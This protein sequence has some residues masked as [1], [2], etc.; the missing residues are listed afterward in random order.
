MTD[1]YKVGDNVWAIYVDRCSGK[2][3]R[4]HNR[5]PMLGKLIGHNEE[6]TQLYWF[7]PYKV[8]RGKVTDELDLKKKIWVGKLYFADTYA[9]AAVEYNKFIESEI[10]FHESKLESLKKCIISID[11]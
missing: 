3:G 7:V 1:N 6:S 2:S 4:I 8:K 11:E 9:E 5:P 10:S